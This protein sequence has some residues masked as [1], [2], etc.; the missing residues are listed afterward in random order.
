[1]FSE[2][3]EIRTKSC[4]ENRPQEELGGEAFEKRPSL[5]VLE[6]RAVWCISQAVV[7]GKVSFLL[8]SA[9]GTSLWLKS[10]L[11]IYSLETLF[12]LLKDS[13][14][15]RFFKALF[16]DHLCD[17]HFQTSHAAIDVSGRAFMHDLICYTCFVSAIYI[18]C[19]ACEIHLL[20]NAKL[21]FDILYLLPKDF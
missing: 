2:P 17:V 7:L 20:W 21:K 13:Y 1:M 10:I 16:V 18:F 15:N 5:F 14:L 19:S 11:I 12:F 8:K 3:C 9:P 4:Y 6:E